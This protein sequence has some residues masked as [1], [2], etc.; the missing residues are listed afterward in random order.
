MQLRELR[1][2]V[3]V[4][5]LAGGENRF[6]AIDHVTVD[7]HRSGKG[8]GQRLTRRSDVELIGRRIGRW[9]EAHAGVPHVRRRVRKE[10]ELARRAWSRR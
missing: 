10:L 4:I 7:L 3:V 8:Q 1:K 5:A 6:R 2:R 9:V